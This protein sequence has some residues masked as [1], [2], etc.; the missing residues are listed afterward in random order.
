MQTLLLIN[1]GANLMLVLAINLVTGLSG[2]LFLG[3]SGLMGIGA[4]TAVSL[5]HYY[6]L[7]PAVTIPAAGITAMAIGCA[8]FSQLTRLPGILMAVVSLIFVQVTASLLSIAP[9]PAFTASIDAAQASTILTVAM[10]ITIA[11]EVFVCHLVEHSRFGR[12]LI[13][14]REEEFLAELLGINKI[15][16]QVQALATGCLFA[17]LAG[18]YYA[19]FTGSYQAAD[20]GLLR[21][22]EI[23]AAAFMG[24]LGGRRGIFAGTVIITLTS[25]FVPDTPYAQAII[26]GVLILLIL[27]TVL[28]RPT[29]LQGS[30]NV[31]KLLQKAVGPC[32]RPGRE[33]LYAA[34]DD[35]Q[36]NQKM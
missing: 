36:R 8:V 23:V 27:L 12:G 13:A 24:G 18:G 19:A 5:A 11:L 22:L 15:G 14:I 21:T 9:A 31:Q 29:G 16:Y 28:L 32:K 26:A 20:W 10:A 1:L 17:G 4:Y 6:H 2:Q 30:V 7:P 25:G 35:G 34:S 3:Y 33:N